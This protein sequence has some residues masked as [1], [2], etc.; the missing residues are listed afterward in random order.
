MPMRQILL[1]PS[2]TL[3]SSVNDDAHS[4]KCFLHVD[5]PLHRAIS[6]VLVPPICLS[7]QNDAPLFGFS[8]RL[9]KFSLEACEEVVVMVDTAG[10]RQ[11]SLFLVQCWIPNAV[12]LSPE[13]MSFGAGEGAGLSRT[14]RTAVLW[15]IDVA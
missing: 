2:H 10:S 11:V 3:R 4:L 1:A 13:L 9:A 12:A 5:L 6:L 15:R 8:V 14:P 7:L